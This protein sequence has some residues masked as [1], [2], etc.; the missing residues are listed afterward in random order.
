MYHVLFKIIYLQYS[1]ISVLHLY[2]TVS[3]IVALCSVILNLPGAGNVKS[4]SGLS[5]GKKQSMSF[6]FFVTGR[7]NNTGKQR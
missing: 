2:K 7:H 4:I 1:D 3:K 5:Y 6:F